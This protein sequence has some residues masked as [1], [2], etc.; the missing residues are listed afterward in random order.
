MLTLGTKIKNIAFLIIGIIAISFIGYNY[1]DLGRYVGI[2]GYYVVKVDLEQAGGLLTNADVTYRGVSVGRVGPVDLTDDGLIA[3]LH[4]KNG[5]P[6]IP[7][8]VEAVVASRSAVGEQFIDLRPK[9]AGGPFLAEGSVVPRSVTTTPQPVTTLLT[10]INELTTSIPLDS[11]RVVVDEL[12]TAFAGQGPNLQ[13]LLDSASAFTSESRKHVDQTNSLITDSETILKTQNSQA[14]ALK[15]FARSAKLL[16]AQL[17]TSDPDLRA[18][19]ASASPAATEFATLLR[20]TDPSFSVVIANLLTT[21]DLLL[22]RKDG[23]EELLVRVPAAVSVGNTV[24]KD[25]KLQ[26]GMVTTF[27]DPLPCTRGYGGTTYR[28]GFETSAAGL[29][30]SARCTMPASTGVNVRGPQNAPKGG[31]VPAAQPGSLARNRSDLPGALG[32][33]SLPERTVDMGALLGVGS[34]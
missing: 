3:S 8:N 5:S 16:D 32:L 23:L 19:I 30:T 13:S 4:I 7:S 31:N 6:K 15:S 18:L 10:S 24:I 2:R 27:F 29:N 9:T 12:G 14:S 17:R 11:L 28:N 25:D 1:A 33:P 21:S 22:S 26:F 20:E 34:R